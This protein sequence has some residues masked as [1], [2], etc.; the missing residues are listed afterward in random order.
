MSLKARITA[1]ELL[2]MPSQSAARFELVKGELRTMPLCGWRHGEIVNNIAVLLGVFVVQNRLGIM[3]AGG[4][5]FLL[6][7]DPDTVR[8]PDHAFVTK[9]HLWEGT[10]GDTY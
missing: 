1:E 10:I 2:A 5:G 6:Q 7:R 8:A 3:F 4:T 9:E